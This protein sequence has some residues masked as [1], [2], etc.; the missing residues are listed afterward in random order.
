[1]KLPKG[2]KSLKVGDIV[3]RFDAGV[4]VNGGDRP[5]VAGEDCVLK[6][7]AVTDGQFHPEE[8]KFIG[9]IER[10]RVTLTPRSD[11]MIMSRAN[12]PELV[13]M[14]AYIDRDYPESFLS[15]KLWQFEPRSGVAFSMRWLNYVLSSMEYRAKLQK[16]ATGSS[17]SMRNI[18]KESVMQLDILFPPHETQKEIVDL[19]STW[20]TAIEKTERLIAAKERLVLTTIQRI[21]DSKASS[22]IHKRVDEIFEE[23][24]NRNCLNDELLSVTQDRGVIPRSML[25]G[26]V[27]S[28]NGTL[29]AYKHVQ[30]GDFV[31]SLRSFQGGLEYSGYMGIISPAY[32]VLRPKVRIETE[33]YRHFFKTY[34]FIQ[35]Y[36]AFSVIGIRDGKQISIPDFM[37]SK[38]PL[39][40]AKEQAEIAFTL[41]LMRKEIDVHHSV[42]DKLKTQKR[43]LMQKLLTGKWRVK[44]S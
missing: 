13:G 42:L 33:F 22:W 18:S 6:V 35:K 7:S 44:A 11:R 24:S 20:D 23:I 19:L 27:M 15:D 41:N 2:W 10:D 43:G 8:N 21:I 39:P 4:S 17:Q 14:C 36:L 38:I 30:S 26:R 34:L 37:I 31:V 1:M 9:G 3:D 5:A 40:P 25:D 32:T 16:L 12:T 29:E 28:P